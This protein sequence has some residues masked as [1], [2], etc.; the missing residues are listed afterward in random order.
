MDSHKL[1]VKFFAD[2]PAAVPGHAFV[3]V[4]HTLIQTR[5]IPEHLLIDVSDYQHVHHG[6]GVLLA[7]HEANFYSDNGE[8]RLGLLYQRKQP[9]PAASGLRDRL[10]H[11]FVAALRAC[12]KLEKDPA[13]EGRLKFRTDE[14]VLKVNDRLLAPNE[15]ETFR[16]VEPDLRA[17]L[18]DL[19][20]G[21]EISLEP[22]HSPLTLFEVR[23][24]AGSSPAVS[25]LL[26]RL[27]ALPTLASSATT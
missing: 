10:A 8:G 26:E 2:N 18:S 20:P 7:A 16:E 11:V 15:P 9:L 22:R 24:K 17:F 3:P 21:D 14:I 1:I 6:P 13:F 4:F 12:E 25:D 5:A 23:V 19:Y 27:E